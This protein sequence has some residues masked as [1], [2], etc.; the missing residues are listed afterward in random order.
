MSASSSLTLLQ[1]DRCDAYMRQVV[2]ARLA[3][4][5]D[6]TDIA[7]AIVVDSTSRCAQ[8]KNL[9]LAYDM[10]S[11]VRK[12]TPKPAY[13]SHW[14]PATLKEIINRVEEPVRWTVNGLL[15]EGATNL[16]SG[17]PHAGKSL[18]WLAGAMQAVT[19]RKVWGKF[20][21]N[22]SIKR[23]LYVE[24]ED[25]RVLVETRVREL[26]K[27]LSPSPEDLYD[28][29][30]LLA[31]TGPFDLVKA[32][33]EI[34][35]L[36]DT[37]KPDWLVLSTLQGLLGGRDWN[38]QDEMAEVNALLVD[39]GRNVVPTS[40]ITH[41]P[42]DARLHRAAGTITQEANHATVLH[43]QKQ[44]LK[45]GPGAGKDLLTISVDSK[46]YPVPQFALLIHSEPAPTP[47]NPDARKLVS[48]SLASE[49]V[50]AAIPKSAKTDKVEAEPD[51]RQKI[52]DYLAEHPEA[53]V[54]EIA[55]S[56]PCSYEYA[57]RMRKDIID[58]AREAED[59]RVF[60]TGGGTIQ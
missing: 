27:H 11:N 29:G 42:K 57:R 44:M 39:L 33:D 28:A 26:A 6:Q 9:L 46:L 13:P 19:T 43:I 22:S 21:V 47:D 15:L 17:Q 53:T 12:L 35:R 48:V 58:D 56:V 16:T 32:K 25:P 51:K 1:D 34:H 41:S 54:Q 24:T 49:D 4:G 50:S 20:Q 52:V 3:K 2:E 38:A 10:I 8:A 45:A 55:D 14:R 37:H 40:V 30:F 31:T 36:L 59:A 23:V 60:G 5:H 18:A 7:N